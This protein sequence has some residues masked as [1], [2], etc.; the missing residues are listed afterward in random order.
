[1]P[2]LY[3]FGSEDK[4]SNTMTTDAL[5]EVTMFSGSAYVNNA[6]YQGSDVPTGSISLHEIN[7]DRSGNG[8]AL[9]YPYIIKG[10]S[11]FTFNNVSTSTY[12]QTLPG[13]I[14][15][16]TY[17]MTASLQREMIA[18]ASLPTSTAGSTDSYFA[19]R[20]RMI[21]LQNTMNYY[22][23]LSNAYEYI[24][25]YV[26]GDVNM[27]S[28]PSIFYDSGIKKGSVSLKF[29]FSGS[30]MDEAKDEKQNGE[31]I[32]TMGLTSG[33]TVGVVLYNEGFLLLTSSAAISNNNYDTYTFDKT[34]LLKPSWKYFGAYTGSASSQ[35]PPS[36]SVYNISFRATNDVPVMTMFASVQPGQLTNSQNPTWISSS[37]GDWRNNS[38]VTS[39]TYVEPDNL[40]IK[41]TIQSQYCRYD[42]EFIK[43]T[44][45]SKIGIFDDE[46]NL[47]AI[48]KVA[49]PVMKQPEDSYTFKLKLDF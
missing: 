48:A 42:G 29:Y 24:G 39:G 19:A 36:S 20:K 11:F 41:N 33:S 17:P 18:A 16:G 5:Y 49:N 21:A 25:N 15:T 44:F 22:R 4:L 27:I 3:R 23:Y 2:Y 26:T 10:E 40:S 8:Q 43:Q 37:N 7:V 28:I 31:L 35:V 34:T 1:M 14:I 30:L 32:S 9:I 45:I 47:I 12:N 6:R 38:N 13:T 46:K